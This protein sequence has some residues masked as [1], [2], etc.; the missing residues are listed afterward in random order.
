MLPMAVAAARMPTRWRVMLWDPPLPED[1][2]QSV[3][4][5]LLPNA[6]IEGEALRS[7][8]CKRPVEEVGGGGVMVD[9]GLLRAA[10]AKPKAEEGLSQV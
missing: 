7:L 10:L 5:R 3:H 4:V 6:V 2:G 1:D 9:K 8:R